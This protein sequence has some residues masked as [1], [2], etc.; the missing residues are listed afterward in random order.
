MEPFGTILGA[1]GSIASLVSIVALWST[2]KPW[3]LRSLLIL[4]FVFTALS[5]FFSFKYYTT[6]QPEA[7]RKAKQ[8][9]LKSSIQA[10]LKDNPIQPSYWEPGQN[11][12]IVKSGLIILELN[13]DLFP[14]SYSKISEDIKVDIEFAQQHRDTQNN[15]EAMDA[16]AKNILTIL[17]ALAGEG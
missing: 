4:V 6:T 10:F 11:E 8:A 14:D 9:E 17:K 5:S 12:G 7:V 3:L 2:Y 16:A 15:R 1:L 13:K